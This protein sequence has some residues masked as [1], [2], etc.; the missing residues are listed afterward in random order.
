MLYDRLAKEAVMSRAKRIRKTMIKFL[1]LPRINVFLAYHLFN[2]GGKRK[3]V[4][5]RSYRQVYRAFG[6]RGMADEFLST[7]TWNIKQRVGLI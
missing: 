3:D 5:G 7:N 2:I 6:N 1:R 4:H